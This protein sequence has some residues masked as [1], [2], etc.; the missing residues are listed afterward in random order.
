MALE[1]QEAQAC[2][3]LAVPSA[4]VKGNPC[5]RRVIENAVLAVLSMRRLLSLPS[6][7]AFSTT[8]ARSSMAGTRGRQGSLAEQTEQFER[9]GQLLAILGR[10]G[11]QDMYAQLLRSVDRAQQGGAMDRRHYNAAV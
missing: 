9:P 11:R 4:E 5:G 1:A 3:G 7:G 10:L 8:L 2:L 6:A